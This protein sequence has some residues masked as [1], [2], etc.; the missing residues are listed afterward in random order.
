MPS[1]GARDDGELSNRND[2]DEVG[3]SDSYVAETE[4]EEKA[5][6][7]Q[8]SKQ[9]DEGALVKTRNEKIYKSSDVSNVLM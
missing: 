2:P 1:D 3:V 5:D 9:D 7:N 6:F 4:E 8:D